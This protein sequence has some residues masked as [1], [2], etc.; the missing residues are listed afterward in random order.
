[1][2]DRKWRLSKWMPDKVIISSLPEAV[3]VDPNDPSLRLSGVF[4]LQLISCRN[5]CKRT[6]EKFCTIGGTSKNN[7]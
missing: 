5:L 1:M 2:E 7:E 4:S 3:M 6:L